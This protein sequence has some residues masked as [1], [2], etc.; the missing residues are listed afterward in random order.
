VESL[1]IE[2][3]TR[4]MLAS[5]SVSLTIDDEAASFFSTTTTPF[6]LLV[7]RKRVTTLTR[8]TRK[9]NPRFSF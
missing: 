4:S 7:K 6:D 3:A 1:K 5:H 8:E 9:K 2:E